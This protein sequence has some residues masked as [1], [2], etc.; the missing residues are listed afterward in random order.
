MPGCAGVP[1]G[2]SP[3]PDQL[4]LALS[5]RDEATFDN[6]WIAPGSLR[7]QLVATL[8]GGMPPDDQV[9]Y[10]WGAPGT[11]CSHLLQAACRQRHLAGEHVQY[12]PL[13]ELV[14]LKPADLLADL[15]YQDLVCL[16]G[17]EQLAGEPAWEEALFNFYNRCRQYGCSLLIG[18][19]CPPR[20]LP[21]RLADLK[22]RL[23]AALVF[24]LPPYT[25]GEKVEILRHRARRL[26]IDLPPAV[27]AFIVTR[28]ERDM[29]S[30]M[31][32]LHRLDKASLAAKRRI[33]LPFVKSVFGW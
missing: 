2:K 3:M 22:S 8:N 15:E 4:S 5:L 29:D 11:G 20:E 24:H 6:Y 21:L 19:G 17:I 18:A 13:E 27:A 25:D 33:T 28:G 10:L 23:S 31:A 12:L 14:A 7:A 30:L 26:G 16:S 1:V 9:V 32:Y